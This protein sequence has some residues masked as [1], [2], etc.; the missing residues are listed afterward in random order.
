MI[1]FYRHHLVR[2]LTM[3]RSRRYQSLSQPRRR[4]ANRT[5]LL[6]DLDHAA[7]RTGQAPRA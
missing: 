4:D 6:T 1:V 2:E 5:Q 7:A 3:D